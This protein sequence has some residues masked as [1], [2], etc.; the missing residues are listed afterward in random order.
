VL[1]GENRAALIWALQAQSSVTVARPSASAT[2]TLGEMIGDDGM[3]SVVWSAHDDVG[4]ELAL[5]VITPEY[6]ETKSL[7]DEMWYAEKLRS[8]RF[9]EIVHFGHLSLPGFGQ[10][11][12][13]VVMELVQGVSVREFVARNTLL[14]DDFVQLVKQLLQARAELELLDL[15]HD[16]LHAGN[17]MI[18]ERDDALS[19]TRE[20]VLRVVDTGSIKRA[21]MRDE[22]LRKLRQRLRDLEE[23]GASPAATAKLRE[24]LAWKV[25]DDHLRSV[26]LMLLLLNNVQANYHRSDPWERQFMDGIE[27]ILHLMIDEDVERRLDSPAGIVAALREVRRAARATQL[28]EDRPLGSPFDYPSSETILDDAEFAKL[29]SAVC[30]WLPEC[31]AVQPVYLYGP[32]GCGKSSVLRWLSFKVLLSDKTRSVADLKEVGV[33]LSCSSELRSR[34]LL[35]SEESLERVQG[36]VIRFFGLL[37]LEELFDTLRVMQEVEQEGRFVF[38]LEDSDSVGLVKAMAA[39]IDP[40]G[41]RVRLQGQAPFEYLR[42]LCRQLRWQEWAQIRQRRAD[43]SDPDS[44]LVSDVT[45]EL[46]HFVPFFQTTHITFL[47][48]DYSNQRIPVSLQRKLNQTISF[49]KQGTPLFKVSSEYDGM[50]LDGIQEGREVLE[51]NC[52]EQ[53][54]RLNDADGYGF[55]EDILNRRLREAKY[56]SEARDILGLSGYTSFAKAIREEMAGGERFYYHGVDCVHQL[57]SGDLALALS[58]VKRLFE[59]PRLSW[60]LQPLRGWSHE[61]HI[62]EVS[63]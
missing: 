52:G 50:D 60:R 46:G 55:L 33:Y 49:A 43:S 13:V 53:Y 26:E 61:Q 18:A 44:A 57:C 63:N 27:R 23:G 31:Q 48:D 3:Q 41:S 56:S 14:I 25:P 7:Y 11:F 36:R 42:G 45:R 47:L 62:K 10:E 58:V 54:T 22:L 34:F 51:V 12:P 32:R 4:R 28:N 35:M 8:P 9:A 38:G 6:Y 37:L 40:S 1:S 21:S 39:R 5:K 2:Y 20:L 19:G 24:F 30:P 29:F 15:V 16:D 17:V 59:P